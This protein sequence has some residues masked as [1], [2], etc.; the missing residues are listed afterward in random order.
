[1]VSQAVAPSRITDSPSLGRR[2]DEVRHQQASK[3]PLVQ[4]HTEPG[5]CLQTRPVQLNHRLVADE[6]CVV[7]GR[8]IEYVVRPQIDRRAILEH[9]AQMPGK[10]Y[11]DM[12]REAPLPPTIGTSSATTPTAASP[13]SGTSGTR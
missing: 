4:A 13:T 2:P 3:Y 6:P 12:T 9:N 10:N 8:D 11:S 1:M 7:S 5:P